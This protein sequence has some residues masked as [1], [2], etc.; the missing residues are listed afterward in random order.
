M[1]FLLSRLDFFTYIKIQK[2]KFLR[3]RKGCKIA[4]PRK[5]VRRVGSARAI[6]E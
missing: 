2:E 1:P 5:N 4:S 3:C 6:L